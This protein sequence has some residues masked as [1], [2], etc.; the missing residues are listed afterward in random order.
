VISPSENLRYRCRACGHTWGPLPLGYVSTKAGDIHWTELKRIM[1]NA[2]NEAKSMARDSKSC[3]EIVRALLEKYG[4]YFTL[5]EVGKVALLGIR[6]FAEEIRFR[7]KS[8]YTR[9]SEELGRC[10]EMI[11]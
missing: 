5:R 1:E 7:D 8:L 4:N 3:E 10:R 11:G 6:G 9:L 2:L